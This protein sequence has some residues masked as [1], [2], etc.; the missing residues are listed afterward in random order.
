SGGSAANG[1]GTAGG[2]SGVRDANVSV[3]APD[4]TGSPSGGSAANGPGTAGGDSGVKDANVSVDAPG[5][6]GGGENLRS[7][8]MDSLAFEG[9]GG[10]GSGQSDRMAEHIQK[11]FPM[12]E[13][14][15][16]QVEIFK[17]MTE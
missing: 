6:G 11:Q 4:Q 14:S 8:V 10:G 1:P 2:N 12:T 15:P 7:A 13:M 5:A 9:G 17:G 3:D 16:L